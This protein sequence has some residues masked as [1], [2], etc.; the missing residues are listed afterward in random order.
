MIDACFDRDEV[1]TKNKFLE[2][3]ARRNAEAVQ[4]GEMLVPQARPKSSDD[5]DIFYDSATELKE[6]WEREINLQT[7]SY[8]KWKFPRLP[9]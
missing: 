1:V 5:D 3:E 6:E 7:I 9:P 4:N 2:E 8:D